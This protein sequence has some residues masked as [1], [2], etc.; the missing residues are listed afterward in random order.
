MMNLDVFL[1]ALCPFRSRL[2]SVWCALLF[3]D[4]PA[5]VNPNLVK[6]APA[7]NPFSDDD[8][9]AGEGTRTPTTFITGT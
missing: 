7:K 9:G 2:R 8:S 1:Q 5:R 6:P 4:Q 3:V